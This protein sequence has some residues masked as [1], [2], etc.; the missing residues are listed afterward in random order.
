M[1]LKRIRPPMHY[2]IRRRVMK[3]LI[4]VLIV[5]LAVPVFAAEQMGFARGNEP[6]SPSYSPDPA[7]AYNSMGG[8]ITVKRLA[9]GKYTVTFDG[10]VKNGMKKSN[11]Q[12]STWGS[13]HQN[14]GIRSWIRP[15][16]T[17]DLQVSLHCVT[18]NTGAD[19]DTRWSVLATI[20]Q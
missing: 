3:K 9:V 20:I 6:A 15:Q 4:L 1:L 14:C 16:G 12:V 17:D 8:A 18:V 7:F 11:V 19:T 5:L 2:R 13:G 10:L